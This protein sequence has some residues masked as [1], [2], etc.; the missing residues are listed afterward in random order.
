M[1]SWLKSIK[2]LITSNSEQ[3]DLYRLLDANI[4]LQAKGLNTIG[5]TKIRNLSIVHADIYLT[6]SKSFIFLP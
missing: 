6:N 2:N 5:K 3:N 1:N 4:C